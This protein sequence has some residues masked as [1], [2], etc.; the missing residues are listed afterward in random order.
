MSRTNHDRESTFSKR[1][2]WFVALWLLGVLGAVLLALPFRLLIAA[3]MH[4]QR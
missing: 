2:L 1:L 4:Y 3:A